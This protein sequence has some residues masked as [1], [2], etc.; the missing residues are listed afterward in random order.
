MG[1]NFA[2]MIGVKKKSI[3]NCQPAAGGEIFLLGCPNATFGQYLWR[4]TELLRNVLQVLK[5]F[6]P[7]QWFEG[8]PFGKPQI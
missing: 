3:L 1:T 7:N 2:K 4:R 6:G 5:S 8:Y